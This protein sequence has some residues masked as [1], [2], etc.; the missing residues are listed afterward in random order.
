MSL[1][2]TGIKKQQTVCGWHV[3]SGPEAR[4]GMMGN[5]DIRRQNNPNGMSQVINLCC[6]WVVLAETETLKE[7]KTGLEVCNQHI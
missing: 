7:E 2:T 1:E 3:Q 4:P 6:V 5:Y